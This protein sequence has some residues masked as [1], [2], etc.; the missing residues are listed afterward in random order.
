MRPGAP[1]EPKVE[2]SPAPASAATTGTALG[3]PLLGIV[4]VLAYPV[5][6]SETPN[7]A[8]AAP[9]LF[10]LPKRASLR[11]SVAEGVPVVSEPLPRTP[12]VLP[13]PR[14]K[15]EFP[16]FLPLSAPVS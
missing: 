1:R 3:N 8:L 4:E 12:T 14:S 15:A 9:M 5:A 7:A 10:V 16:L 11:V 6:I 13:E 2:E